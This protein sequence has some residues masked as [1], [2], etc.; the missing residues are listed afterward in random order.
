MA[1]L[2]RKP[3]ADTNSLLE[4]WDSIIR[5]QVAYQ[6][7]TY[8]LLLPQGRETLTVGT[9]E[10]R[11]DALRDF[12]IRLAAQ[13]TKPALVTLGTTVTA[14]YTAAR[15]L[16]DLQ[17]DAKTALDNSRVAQEALRQ[18]SAAALINMVGA[19]LQVFKT[20]PSLVDTLF[21]V[22][23]L[24]GGAQQVPEAPEDTVVDPS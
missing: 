15:S 2:T 6:G 12:G 21:D 13:T 11:L 14:F 17:T 5:S 16:R 18:A 20:S 7:P 24:R 3:D 10:A 1:S 19:G 4:T 8:M 22:N 23:L 9:L